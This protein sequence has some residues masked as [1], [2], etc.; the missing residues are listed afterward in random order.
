M[1][2]RFREFRVNGHGYTSTIYRPRAPEPDELVVASMNRKYFV[3]TQPVYVERTAVHGAKGGLMNRGFQSESGIFYSADA[4]IGY[5]VKKKLPSGALCL[6]IGDLL[7]D[8]LTPDGELLDEWLKANLSGSPD[9]ACAAYVSEFFESG[10][11]KRQ[12]EMDIGPP[13]A[14]LTNFDLHMAR[15]MNDR[16]QHEVPRAL[17]EHRLQAVNGIR[18]HT[19][20]LFV[21]NMQRGMPDTYIAFAP[22]KADLVGYVS[23][24]SDER[25]PHLGYPRE[26]YYVSAYSAIDQNWWYVQ[27]NGNGTNPYDKLNNPNGPIYPTL[28]DRAGAEAFEC[29]WA[30]YVDMT[31]WYGTTDGGYTPERGDPKEMPTVHDPN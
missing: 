16:L 18:R 10:L 12:C 7:V 13:G 30:P 11:W 4:V 21:E 26:G 20:G 5:V 28:R 19:V 24:D 1:I 22:S 29:L 15:Y 9:T 6:V 8:G 25:N 3:G 23:G 17:W 27:R 2:E 14:W 31:C